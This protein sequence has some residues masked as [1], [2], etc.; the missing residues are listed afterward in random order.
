[1]CL[2]NDNFQ[3]LI[4]RFTS[5]Q[6]P[7][8]IR[9]QHRVQEEEINLHCTQNIRIHCTQ[10]GEN[11]NL[12]LGG[13]AQWSSHLPQVQKIRVRITPGIRFFRQSIETLLW[14]NDLTFIISVNLKEK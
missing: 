4:F 6:L 13:V 14:K 10:S 1:L 12:D 5:I 7:A 2:E 9:I 3:K 8:C 11:E